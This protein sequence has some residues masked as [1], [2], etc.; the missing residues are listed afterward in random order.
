M[1]SGRVVATL[2]FNGEEKLAINIPSTSKW[3]LCTRK[4]Y[5]LHSQSNN[6]STCCD[7]AKVSDS[8][9]SLKKEV[10]GFL[11]QHTA[12]SN[13]ANDEGA[14]FAGCAVIL[15]M[16][17]DHQ[18][19]LLQWETYGHVQWTCLRRWCQMRRKRQS[20]KMVILGNPRSERDDC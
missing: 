9:V 6:A 3:P 13:L 20:P 4:M 17:Y 18:V 19:A 7:A 10:V 16:C 5:A 8:V 15:A 2:A 1:Q 14:F 12:A 11:S